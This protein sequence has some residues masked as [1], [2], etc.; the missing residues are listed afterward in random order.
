MLT[1]GWLDKLCYRQT[2]YH[3]NHPRTLSQF[4]N[5]LTS[6]RILL[7]TDLPFWRRST[8]AEQRIARLVEYLSQ[9]GYC[10]RIF[11]LCET[12]ELTQDNSIIT[13]KDQQTI[14]AQ[15]LDIEF[16]RSSHPPR[17]LIKKAAWHLKAIKHRLK[18][19]RTRR[20]QT[21]PAQPVSQDESLLTAIPTTL[22]DYR[23]PWAIDAFQD[24]IR[25]FAPDSVIIEYVK[26]SYL[27][28]ALTTS[29]RNKIHCL[30]DTHDVLH[31]RNKQFQ[32]RGLVHWLDI[33]QEEETQAVQLFDTILAIQNEEAV[34]FRNLAPKQNVLVCGHAPSQPHPL[35]IQPTTSEILT[36]GYIASNNASNL[37]SL[38]SFIN[39][40]WKPISERCNIRLVIAGMICDAISTSSPDLFK[41]HI[42]IACLGC[43]SEL[44]DFYH[45]IDI[46]I[47]PVEFGTGLKIKN[48]EAIFFGKPLVTT[49][50]GMDGF[51][52][53][54]GE[55]LMVCNS[56]KD[57]V[58]CLVEIAQNP[59][60][61]TSLQEA[62]AK[63][64]QTGFS[65]QEVYSELDNAL[66]HKK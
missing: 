35:K 56:P 32:E 26:L 14:R 13:E 48:C 62:A 44:A 2:L 31:L 47:N 45:Q 27:L 3:P 57:W 21:S 33:S 6:H 54:S 59:S 46:A 8:G 58:D 61:Q 40:S 5:S 19:K 18:S 28:E 25:S 15:K 20:N 37:Q 60:R 55:S 51:S 12:T 38:T 36:V 10:V 30:L 22:A 63:L 66:R 17:R 16:K 42:N 34:V 9:S 4:G 43:V 11:L 24:S 64:S 52:A 39:Q 53:E 41:K 65:D 23:W 29:Q 1:T 49:T 7:A 50:I